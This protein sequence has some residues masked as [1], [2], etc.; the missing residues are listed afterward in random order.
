MLFL[1]KWHNEWG[2][3]VYFLTPLIA[4]GLDP[5][6]LQSARVLLINEQDQVNYTVTV[7][8]WRPCI[9]NNQKCPGESSYPGSLGTKWQILLLGLTACYLQP[10]E[11]RSALQFRRWIS[12]GLQEFLLFFILQSKAQREWL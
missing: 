7:T 2:A 4:S 9:Q 12:V 3:S 6:L 11:P 5:L 10:A 8:D 1:F